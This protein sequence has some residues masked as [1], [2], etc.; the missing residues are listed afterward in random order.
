M[1][2]ISYTIPSDM[3]VGTAVTITPTVADGT[4]SAS[5]TWSV[6]T[7]TLPAG[8]SIASATG[9]ISGTPTT[10]GTTTFTVTATD[11]TT[12]ITTSPSMTI[13][14]AAVATG[15]TLTAPDGDITVGV[16]VTL[17]LSLVGGAPATDITVT[18]SDG[19]AGGSFDSNTVVFKAGVSDGH[20]RQYTA[21]GET[22]ATISATNSGNLTDPA[23]LSLVSVKPASTSIQLSGPTSGTAGVAATLSLTANNG[24]PA[25]DDVITPSDGGAGGTFTPATVT[26]GKGVSDPVEFTY[27]PADASDGKTVTL[28]ATDSAKIGVTG[29]VSMTVAAN[30]A[31][32]Y[33]IS[34]PTAGYVNRPTT[35]TLTP[36][37][38]PTADITLTLTDGGKGGTFTPAT[39]KFA[40]GSTA[41]Q[42]ATYTPSTTGSVTVAATNSGSLVD[43]GGVTLTIAAEPT[44]LLTLSGDASVTVG[45][46]YTLTVTPNKNGPTDDDVLTPD[47][48]AAGGTFNPE[49]LTIPKGSKSAAV[50][51]YTPAILGG[52]TTVQ[53]EVKDS[54]GLAVSDALSVKVNPNPNLTYTTSLSKDRTYVGSP[55]VITVQPGGTG[56]AKDTT[57]TFSDGGAGGVFTPTSVTIPA[58]ST[59]T[60]TSSYAPAANAT[61]TIMTTNNGGLIDASALTLTVAPRDADT[62]QLEGPTGIVVGGKGSISVIANYNGPLDATTVT[63]SDGGAG[64]TFTPSTVTLASGQTTASAVSYTPP[65]SYSGKNVAVS[66]TNSSGLTVANSLTIAVNA[67]TSENSI[68]YNIPGRINVGDVLDITPIANTNIPANATWS[69]T[70]GTLPDGMSINSST[71]D[72]TGTPST[73]AA[74]TTTFTV[75]ASNGTASLT[76]VVALKVYIPTT[77]TGTPENGAI[78]RPFSFTFKVEGDSTA[79]ASL[80]NDSALP[81]GVSFDAS[82]MTI[83]G[84]PLEGGHFIADIVADGT[85]SHAEKVFDLLIV[86]APT[87]N[88]ASIDKAV[89]DTVSIEPTYDGTSGVCTFSVYDG[90]LAAGLDLDP[91][92]GI[93]SGKPTADGSYSAT[94]K[95]TDATGG[96][97]NAIVKMTIVNQLTLVMPDLTT[98]FG[99]AANIIPTVSGGQSP[100]TFS[101]SGDTLSAIQFDT[102]TGQVSTT[103]SSPVGS[104][105]LTIK[106][107]DAIGAVQTAQFKVTINQKITLVPPTKIPPGDIGTPYTLE[108]AVSGGIGTQTSKISTG[109][110]P[111]GL[112]LTPNTTTITG[113]PT[114]DGSYDVTLQVTDASGTS[115]LPLNITIS[116][117]LQ[118]ESSFPYGIVGTPY[119]HQ[120][121]TTG[122]YSDKE[123]EVTGTLPDGLEVNETTGVIFGT[124]TTPGTSALQVT[125]TDGVTT[126][127]SPVVLQIVSPVEVSYAAAYGY[128]NTS[129]I[130]TPKVQGGHGTVSFTSA[131]LPDG[132]TIDGSTGVITGSATAAMTATVNVTTTDDT[133]TTSETCRIVVLNHLFVT[134]TTVYPVLGEAFSFNVGSVVSGGDTSK[135]FTSVSVFPT[136]LTFDASTGIISG[137][138]TGAPASTTVQ[139]SVTDTRE[140]KMVNIN[141]QAINTIALK[142]KPPVG[143]VGEAY[144]YQLAFTGGSGTQTITM[145]STLPAGLAYDAA[146]QTIS[147]TPTVPAV[148]A[149]AYT[150]TDA[151]GSISGVLTLNIGPEIGI[152]GIPVAAEV[153]HPYTFTPVVAGGTGT[154]TFSYTGTLPAGLNFNKSSGA[155]FGTPTIDGLANITLTVTDGIETASFVVGVVVKKALTVSGLISITCPKNKIFSQFSPA[156]Y[157]AGPLSYALVAGTLPPGVDL[158]ITTGVLS[159]TPTQSGLYSFSVQVT[160]LY[161]SALQ[162]FTISVVNAG[163]P[164]GLE[165]PTQI[166]QTIDTL[167]EQYT[168]IMLN[169]AST[170]QQKALAM[171]YLARANRY[172]ISW[173]TVYAMTAFWTLYQTYG[174]TILAENNAF[175]YTSQVDPVYLY[176]LTAVYTAYHGV[177]AYPNKEL[178]LSFLIR[179]TRSQA[180]VSFLEVKRRA[181]LAGVD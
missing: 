73:A 84:T 66:I 50:F 51:S 153:G 158:D 172:M 100:Y 147:G 41:A 164:A 74:G 76:G 8:L 144:T 109:A 88:Y 19:S 37:A 11:G 113:T 92:T 124:P 177:I 35:V 149:L 101:I 163:I 58:G 9:I 103:V 181:I 133:G 52:G 136:G 152:S 24:G 104:E 169:A 157:G 18:L 34:A 77:I 106:V 130:I 139:V 1:P 78:S 21:A 137:T 112:S 80:A 178:D 156:Q 79:V 62:L 10:A 71:G 31:H 173:P 17:S 56:P 59:A 20:T 110:L 89:G 125:V 14:A 25:A 146:T 67:Q 2:T 97:A 127:E 43:P 7:G 131:D 42:T 129:M 165:T 33:Q 53:L 154:Y 96:S 159:G 87:L 13:A 180:L 81:N 122:G 86:T 55:S 65:A 123:Y 160:D 120:I 94:I 111:P 54:L 134:D 117:A 116:K 175:Q 143:V 93:I 83:S 115:T 22:T 32:T 30:P 36:G 60:A 98:A 85:N 105:T 39:V 128:P 142:A 23:S 5:E 168:T 44:D 166:D 90:A 91:D 70:T 102:T 28:S 155:I 95:I 4:L 161:T 162:Q 45:S 61:V 179:T 99:V 64:G 15:Y 171:V 170:T 38:A 121:Q 75:T 46:T 16:P 57:I 141:I 3:K 132:F 29:S 148:A 126:V 138:V 27:T 82:T 63:F 40:S 47:D 26:I 174:S 68:T 145:P 167:I 108:V 49:T 114:A 107:A 118:L 150:C 135:S 69:V 176:E 151:T 12:P 48:K 6:T 72:I 119:S 140:T